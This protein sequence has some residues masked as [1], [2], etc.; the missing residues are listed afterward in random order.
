MNDS[1]N[2]RLTSVNDGIIVENT[3][4]YVHTRTQRIHYGPSINKA[5][6]QLLVAHT[7]HAFMMPQQQQQRKNR[8]KRVV[9]MHIQAVLEHKHESRR[10]KQNDN[11]KKREE[12]EEYEDDE[13]EYSRK[14]MRSGKQ[15]EV[16]AKA[17]SQNEICKQSRRT[18]RINAFLI[19]TDNLLCK[20][21][22]VCVYVCVYSY[23]RIGK[24]QA[25]CPPFTIQH[26]KLKIRCI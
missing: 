17:N 13:E 21:R 25:Q 16:K 10:S 20:L 9:P 6:L 11:Q 7:E 5:S 23:I 15:D 2:F 26:L 14:C 8:H 3:Q 1:F 19:V 12:E 24:Q 4:A 18:L 22:C